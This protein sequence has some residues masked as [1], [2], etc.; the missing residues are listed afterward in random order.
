M[1]LKNVFIAFSGCLLLS[2][3]HE[4]TGPDEP[5]LPIEYLPVMER[6]PDSPYVP[7]V[8]ERTTPEPLYPM[9]PLSVYDDFCGQEP[10]YIE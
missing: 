8:I 10:I 2:C 3:S 5:V 7:A 1:R 4:E 6:I 9:L